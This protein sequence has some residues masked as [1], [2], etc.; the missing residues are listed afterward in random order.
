MRYRSDEKIPTANQI[1]KQR[2][3]DIKVPK[4]K[5]NNK[6]N[7][8]C[9]KRVRVVKIGVVES[10]FRTK[11]PKSELNIKCRA[12][13]AKRVRVVKIGV[14]ETRFRDTNRFVSNAYTRRTRHGRFPEESQI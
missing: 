7:A 6:G 9:A 8:H 2:A 14:V 1:T 4:S 3:L 10:R 13:C 12:H 11:S 5:L